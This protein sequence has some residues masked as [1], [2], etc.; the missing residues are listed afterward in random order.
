[1]SED[2]FFRYVEIRLEV[3]RIEVFSSITT[4]VCHLL[5]LKLLLSVAFLTTIEIIG[6]EC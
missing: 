1:M 4:N 2:F 6:L 5:Q 3:F